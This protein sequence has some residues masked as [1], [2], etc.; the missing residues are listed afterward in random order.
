MDAA[1]VRA[2]V[3]RWVM[4][5]ERGRYMGGI[6]HRPVLASAGGSTVVDTTGKAYLDFQSGQ[7][8]AALGHR[9]P[10]VMAA[11]RDDSYPR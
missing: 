10:R 1:R 9:H 8:G 4:P 3:E 5:T 6:E 7:M 11:I 2:I